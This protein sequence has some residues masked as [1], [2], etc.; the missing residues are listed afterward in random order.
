MYIKNSGYYTDYQILMLTSFKYCQI[1]ILRATL[2]FVDFLGRPIHEFNT[3]SS[4][5]DRCIFFPQIRNPRNR[6]YMSRK[7][8]SFEKTIQFRIKQY[9]CFT[10]NKKKIIAYLQCKEVHLIRLAEHEDRAG[11]R[12]GQELAHALA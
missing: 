2:I 3:I 11:V 5:S 9:A 7:T 12:V 1:L 10:V 4:E 6:I 8:S